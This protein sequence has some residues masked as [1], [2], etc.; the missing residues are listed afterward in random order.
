MNSPALFLV[1]SAIWGST[2]LAI[3][4]QLG[5]VSPIASVTYRF[6]IATVI[7]LAWCRLRGLPLRFPW[8]THLGIAGQGACLFSLN[9]LSIYIAEQ[10]VSSG[11]VAIIFSLQAG[12]NVFGARV[13]F[14]AP[15]AART[16]FAAVLG[17][18]GV[19]LMFYPEFGMMRNH[20]EVLKGIVFGALGTLFASGGNMVA[21]YNNQRAQVPV[22]SGAAW[23]M[24][25]GTALSA[26]IGVVMG[27]EWTFDARPTYIISL[28]YLSVFGTIAAFLCY[29]TL[30][31]REGAG[32]ASYVNVVTPVV[33]LL[34]STLFENYQWTMIAI[35]GAAL[36][37]V[38]NFLVMRRR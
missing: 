32:L 12:L 33:A 23:G 27:V 26:I 6:A 15:V 14:G 8:R 17:V 9:Y 2:W 34:L 29:L 4:G 30:L 21:I 28:L 3:T 35:L 10:Y 20:P 31:K 1:T 19:A 36:A 38:G 11:L 7:L 25:Y 22:W 37:F 13:L 16:V 5:V 24:V 18:G